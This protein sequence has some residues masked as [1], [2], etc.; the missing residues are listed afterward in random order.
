MHDLFVKY[1]VFNC[2]HC[3][4][5]S[6]SYNKCSDGRLYLQNGPDEKVAKDYIILKC[7]KCD[8]HTFVIFNKHD[9]Y[10]NYIEGNVD[11]LNEEIELLYPKV[12][13]NY[14]PKQIPVELT[15][16][17]EEAERCFDVKSYNG[18][19]SCIRKAVHVFLKLEGAET[20]RYDDR[21]K[22]L[23]E[24]YKYHPHM[25]DYLTLFKQIHSITSDQLHESSYNGLNIESIDDY[26]SILLE[27]FDEVYV[28]K[29]ILQE[30]R[31]K[32]ELTIKAVKEH[33]NELKKEQVKIS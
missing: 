33:Q 29:A 25:D 31:K 26:I 10:E 1:G 8:C 7:R 5:Q 6:V 13:R 21:I 24:E 17:I 22:Q 4:T 30:K 12:Y 2:I 15:S 9:S 11:L 32:V 19:F 16:L 27:C 14:I 20:G 23:K 18:A 28:R 3:G